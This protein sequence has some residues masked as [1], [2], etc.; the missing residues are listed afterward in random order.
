M[1]LLL[2]LMALSVFMV[3]GTTVDDNN[4]ASTV[5][6]FALSSEEL[7]SNTSLKC[8]VWDSSREGEL[9]MVCI[10]EREG[11][12][13]KGFDTISENESLISIHGGEKI[14]LSTYKNRYK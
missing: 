7:M 8:G 12:T 1:K 9:N 3:A 5:Q 6:K 13:P 2:S 4:S 11:F 10:A 14:S